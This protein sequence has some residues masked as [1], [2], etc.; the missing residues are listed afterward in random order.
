MKLAIDKNRPLLALYLTGLIW[1]TQFASSVFSLMTF[2]I[3]FLLFLILAIVMF[4]IFSIKGWEDGLS[5]TASLTIGF[6]LIPQIALIIIEFFKKEQGFHYFHLG[7][8][9]LFFAN[10]YLIYRS[11]GSKN[12]QLTNFV[13]H[14]TY[15]SVIF[16]FK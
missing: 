8:L 5:K 2:K 7:G 10:T 12:L 3:P 15:H 1:L 16:S 13:I 6:M 11:K 4:L 9:I 14:L